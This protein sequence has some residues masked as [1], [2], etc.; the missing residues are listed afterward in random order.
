MSIKF[1]IGEILIILWSLIIITW[2]FIE[3]YAITIFITWVVII[4]LWS[5]IWLINN[6]DDKK[7]IFWQVIWV[8]LT[9]IILFLFSTQLHNFITEYLNEIFWITII[10]LFIAI[11]WLRQIKN[12]FIKSELKLLVI[13][14]LTIVVYLIPTRLKLEKHL[15]QD[16]TNRAENKKYYNKVIEENLTNIEYIYVFMLFAVF[17]PIVI[18]LFNKNK[19][20]NNSIKLDNTINTLKNIWWNIKQKNNFVIIEFKYNLSHSSKVIYSKVKLPKY[21]GDIKELNPIL[22]KIMKDI[23]LDIRWDIKN[24]LKGS[25]NKDIINYLENN[26]YPSYLTKK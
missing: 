6:P 19:Y 7:E 1:W 5:I 3:P 26:I 20:Q 9:S 21:L 24:K 14:I 8:I 23:P 12:N 11:L 16:H 4:W 15:N 13:L 10:L 2:F 17:L 18:E 25:L 22:T